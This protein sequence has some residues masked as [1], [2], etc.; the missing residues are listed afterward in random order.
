MVDRAGS[1]FAFRLVEETG[2]GA[3]RLARGYAVAR[4]VFEM[5]TFWAAV[6]ELDNRVEADTQIEMLIEGRRLVERATRW[7]VRAHP[8]GI[9][10]EA[11]IEQFKP[12]A[13]G[14]AGALPG[15]LHGA[16]RE[17]FDQR[18][19]GLTEAGVPRELARRVAGMFS[20][21]S[22]F[23]ITEVAGATGRERD[24]VMDT[25]FTIGA[26]LDLN[27]L[28]DRIIELPRANRW[29]ALARA[30]LRDD[31]Y[32]LHRALTR[33]VLETAGA[34]LTGEEALAAWSAR[35]EAALQRCLAMIGDIRASRSYDMT[36][37]PVGLREVRNLIRGGEAER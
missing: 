37:L 21:L 17:A 3:S 36:T 35:H 18:V 14:L 30:A 8:D 16:D 19:G 11:T 28:R 32:A 25:Y 23:D 22:A 1:T 6:E 4:E 26:R 5:R 10:I 9:A 29:Q 27:W 34:D 12:G 7:L 24:A 15:V 20:L 13:D 33:E 2:A 31:V